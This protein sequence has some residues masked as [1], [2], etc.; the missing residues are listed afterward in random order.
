MN[1]RA[2][3][4]IDAL[5]GPIAPRFTLR[6]QRA[7]FAAEMLARAYEAASHGRRTMG[8]NRSGGDVNAVTRR[9]IADL[10]RVAHDLVE[11]N[12]WAT[13]ALD[14]IVDNTV[15]SG[16]VAKPARSAPDAIRTRALALWKAWAESTVCDAD[17]RHDFAG[18]EKLVMRTVAESGEAL[19]RR[20]IRRLEDGLPLPLQLQVL[21][22]DYLDG[23]RDTDSL[24]NGGRII[25][26]VEFDAIGRRRGYWLFREH[27]ESSVATTTS[28]FVPA[29]EVLHVFRAK[30]PG[31]VRGVSWFHAVALR[32]KDFDD[33]ENA[34]LM[35]QK[36]AACLAVI[37]SDADGSA[38]ALGVEKEGRSGGLPIDMLEPGVIH[39]APPGSSVSVV[40][41]PSVSEHAAYSQG[42]LR[43]IASGLGVSYEG[44]TGDFSVVNFSSARMAR[45]R[46]WAHVDD[47]RWLM[48]VPQFLDPVW[49]WAMEAAAVMGLPE[50]PKAEWT[51]PPMAMIEPDKEGLAY[52]R[53]VRAG[54]MTLSEAIRERGYDPDDML[55]EMAADWKTV[56]RLKLILDSDPRNTTQ[57]GQ[58]RETAAANAPATPPAAEPTAD[59]VLALLAEL[60]ARQ[61]ATERRVQRQLDR[62]ELAA[63]DRRMAAPD[64]EPLVLP[65]LSSHEPPAPPVINVDARTTIE[66]G[67]FRFEPPAVQVDART[68]V[69]PARVEIAPA[70]PPEVHVDARTT[71]A[72]GAV[73][74]EAPV[75]VQQA[76]APPTVTVVRTAAPPKPEDPPPAE[77]TDAE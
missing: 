29:S 74:L 10:R 37:Y 34:A 70:A 48:L 30:R 52:A 27:P 28:A 21:E 66:P 9:G 44:M 16:I 6:R 31:Q 53:N 24:P 35:K 41:P 25:Q 49:G 40:Q 32:M 38:P 60:S 47:W 12:A 61:E 5:T 51:A 69:E 63:L 13:A 46:H 75:T 14:E 11:N 62:I 19:V 4:F 15:G 77:T 59:R 23:L 2:A 58:P 76:P 3:R 26:G 67:A 42:I 36:V 8:W 71:I 20:R 50:R 64:P 33:Y 43:A 39:T 54:I 22:P 65:S 55:N 56:D 45:L 57:A 17:G 68:T 18:I 7:R 1:D 73:R 72:E